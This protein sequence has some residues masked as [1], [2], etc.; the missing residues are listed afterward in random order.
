MSGNKKKGS[1]D[2]MGF[3]FFNALYVYLC[4]KVTLSELGMNWTY[5]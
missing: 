1:G 4:V 5:Q 2:L 3:Y